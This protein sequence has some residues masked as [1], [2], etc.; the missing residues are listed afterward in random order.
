MNSL[1]TGIFFVAAALCQSTAANTS[2]TF[3]F[4]GAADN[5]G[6]S[7]GDALTMTVS[8]LTV[9]ETAWYVASNASGAVFSKAAVDNYN[10]YGLGVCDTAETCS[11]P[12]HQI[13][14]LTGIDFVELIFSAP[15]NLTSSVLFN[16]APIGGSVTD[17]DMTYYTASTG[18]T[19]ATTLG[20]LGSGTQDNQACPGT[21]G[22]TCNMTSITD[23]LAGTNV[24]T[25][26]IAASVPNADST[27][28]AFKLSA[29]TVSSAT[30][31][32]SSFVMLAA[33]SLALLVVA[34]RK[35]REGRLEPEVPEITS[36]R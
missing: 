15:V 25:L 16:Y 2:Y 5:E 17:V 1:S 21:N 23:T 22:S 3:N 8:G 10:P 13:D 11:S 18:L 14:N 32:P 28:D 6:N 30:P 26:L 12:S 27:P 19:T 4:G 20:S 35:R 7:F 34:L 9:T 36:A 31:E 24:T 29:V 33:G